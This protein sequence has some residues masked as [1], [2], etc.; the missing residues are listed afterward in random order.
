ML[1]SLRRRLAARLGVRL[2]SALAAAVVVAVAS[3]IAGAVL[4][5]IA[6]GILV[7]NVNTAVDDR[8]SRLAA[9]LAGGGADLSSLLRPSARDHTVVQ[10]L[11]GSGTVVA[12]S[13]ALAGQGPISPL[14]PGVGA[15]RTDEHWLPGDHDDPF[16]IVVLTVQTPVGV[17]TVLAGE[18]LDSV[19]DDMG[20]IAAVLALGLPLLAAVV[21]AATFLFV[22]RTLR[23]VEAMRR[24]A[25]LITSSNLHERLPVPAAG[26]EIAALAETMNT[27]LDRIE[28]ASAAQKRFVGDA[29]HELRSPLA[30]VQANADLLDRA[31]LPS[32]AARSVGRI[33]TE[34]ARM[35]RLVE[36]LLLLARFDDGGS[37]RRRVQDVDLD[38][39]V[40]TERERLRL[41]RPGLSLTVTLDPV[42]V[43]GDADA[44]LRAV[45]NLLDNA[46][47]HASSSVTVAVAAVG[48]T[49]EIVIANDGPPIRSA[50]R[51]RIFGR[52]VR[53][54]DSRS[55]TDGGS[56]LGLAIARDIVTAHG[57]TLTVDD[58]AE[59]AAMR[60]RL[61]L[62]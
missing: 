44:L 19:D 27:M 15:R 48:E 45:R 55:R 10:V 23:P 41:E 2:R 25:A 20:A 1:V 17:R 36:D 13:D 43:T 47:R 12:A 9:A 32:T 3:L 57:G 39:I 11:D 26:D 8:A 49:A 35:A 6:R 33:R 22:G 16:R 4:L 56:G 61:P 51:D 59:G 53:L 40:Y 7:N 24:Q 21:G 34:S 54:D 38:D 28:A 50:D 52:F 18:S 31:D 62:S 14:R 58:L 42:R 30:T 29:S 60:I 5:I 46:A 37:L